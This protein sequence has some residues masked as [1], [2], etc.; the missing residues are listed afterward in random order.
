MTSRE[1]AQLGYIGISVSDVDKWSSF[2]ADVLG[3][4]VASK[5][6]SAL[7]LRMDEYAYRINVVQGADDDLLYAG[8]QVAGRHELDDVKRR[9]SEQGIEVKDGSAAE[10]VDRGVQSMAWFRDPDGLR[11]EIAF[12]MTRA[13]DPVIYGRP[14]T[15]FKAGDQGLG[16]IVVRVE[17]R[18]EAEAFYTDLLGL[19]VSDY[20][21]GRLAFLNCNSRHHSIA[22]APRAIIPGDKRLVHVMFELNSI[23]DVGT[24]IDVA[25]RHEYFIPENLGRHTNDGMLSFYIESPSGFQIEYGWGARE[26]PDTSRSIVDSYDRKD[27]W[28]HRRLS[29]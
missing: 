4:Q 11:T 7:K 6:D 2:G 18:D 27:V 1:I 28:G 20:G 3:M 10:L 9:V 22:F 25:E 26:L 15:G 23:D 16:H 12:G 14:I 24:A 8:W 5:S 21:S 29:R 17:S 13:S 19:A